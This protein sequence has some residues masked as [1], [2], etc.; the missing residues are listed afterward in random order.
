M[1]SRRVTAFCA[2]SSKLICMAGSSSSTVFTAISCWLPVTELA[3]RV[4]LYLLWDHSFSIFLLIFFP[5]RVSGGNLCHAICQIPG[6]KVTRTPMQWQAAELQAEHAMRLNLGLTHP[7]LWRMRD[8]SY[9][10]A[11]RLHCRLQRKRKQL[12][13]S[14]SFHVPARTTRTK[15]TATAIAKPKSR[16]VKRNGAKR[17]QLQCGHFVRTLSPAEKR[18]SAMQKERSVQDITYA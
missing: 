9:V 6:D 15:G 5:R 16:K 3:S 17:K 2:K 1:E 11:R 8:L 14:L 10:Y 12:I 4:L 7:P 13:T 18:K